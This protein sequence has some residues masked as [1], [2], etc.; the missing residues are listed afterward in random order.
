MHSSGIQSDTVAATSVE[1][2]PIEEQTHAPWPG[3]HSMPRWQMGEL[4]D[5]PQF[6]LRNWFGMLGPGL[7]MGGAAIGGGEWLAGPA[8][9]ARYGGALMWLATVSIVAQVFYNLE[10]SRYTLYTGE[11]I[12]TGKFRTFPGPRLWVLIYLVLDIGCI[13][14]YLASSAATP[15][16]TVCLGRMPVESD[17]LLMRGLAFFVFFLAMMPLIFGGKIYDV[18]KK[19][20]TFKIVTVFGFLIFIGIFHS[21][22]GTWQEIFS[23]FGK[24][25]TVPIQRG[26]DLNGNGALDQGEDWDADGHLDVVEPQEKLASGK[27]TFTDVDGDGV[28]DGDNLANVF[29]AWWR[30]EGVPSID[31]QG[32]ALLAAFA[33]IAG[34]GGLTNIPISNYTRDQGWGMGKHVGAI[35]SIVGGKNISL[36]HVGMV[37]AINSQSVAKFRRWYRHVLRDQLVVWM[38]AC[39]LGVALPSMLSVQFLRRGTE[40]NGWATAVM[41]AEGVQKHVDQAWGSLWGLSMWYMMLFCGFL[42][43][44]PSAASMGDGVVRRWVDV[45]WT[46]SARLRKWDPKQIK[47][48][49]F[50][51]LVGYMVTA[52][53]LMAFGNPLELFKVAAN[54]MNFALGVSCWHTLVINTTLLP[55]ALRPGWFVRI[56][57]ALAGIFFLA[58]AVVTLWTFL[59]PL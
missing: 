6:T 41:T 7:L 56:G 3:I 32:I 39:F 45:F 44:A 17:W 43:L 34:G 8:V 24:F 55:P 59:V 16:A 18:L 9:T 11:P 12:F 30:G 4:G 31:L 54:F 28:R 57:L 37:F 23:G 5:A 49:Y 38:P 1:K 58:L 52:S 29:T 26:E 21:T 20:M 50:A 14:P 2:K 51:V 35:P 53:I 46:S 22:W 47:Y 40:V 10:I 25:G 48:L 27:T 13:I 36:S 33:G 15:L 19:V 42:V